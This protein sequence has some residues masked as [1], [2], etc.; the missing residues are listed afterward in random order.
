MP[1]YITIAIAQQ[2]SG[3]GKSSVYKIIKDPANKV[4]TRAFCMTKARQKK[5]RL[6][7]YRDLVAY[8]D[9]LPTDL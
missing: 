2:L 9:R 3:L 4:R 6:V 7:N 8:L 5:V 1:E